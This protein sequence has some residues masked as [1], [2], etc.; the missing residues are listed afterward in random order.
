[1]SGSS[2][3]QHTILGSTQNCCIQQ[4]IN[5]TNKTNIL[6]NGSANYFW[7]GSE[8]IAC[9]AGNDERSRVSHHGL[10]SSCTSSAYHGIGRFSFHEQ[11]KLTSGDDDVQ[12]ENNNNKTD[13]DDK[14]FGENPKRTS[15]QMEQDLQD[16][17]R[18]Q[19]KAK[20]NVTGGVAGD[21]EGELDLLMGDLKLGKGVRCMLHSMFVC[22][23]MYILITLVLL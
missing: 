23:Y 12:Y 9:D 21:E 22:I 19:K 7:S 17:C 18:P 2:A 4:H 1:M 6:G 11:M 16:L 5:N 8:F 15:E 14:V 20:S 3:K 10:E 13:S